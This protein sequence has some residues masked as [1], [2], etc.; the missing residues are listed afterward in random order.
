MSEAG[1]CETCSLS[2]VRS[3]KAFAVVKKPYVMA[4]LYIVLVRPHLE[5]GAQVWHPHLAKHTN[6]IENVQKFALRICSKKWNYT[7]T[8]NYLTCFNCQL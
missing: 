4:K 8:G 6:A 2:S 7:A 5:Y 1:G 3:A